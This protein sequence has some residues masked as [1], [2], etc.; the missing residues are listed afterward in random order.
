[1]IVPKCMWKECVHAVSNIWFQILPA[2]SNN[3]IIY[4][5]PTYR[6]LSRFFK[7]L[8]AQRYFCRSVTDGQCLMLDPDMNMSVFTDVSKVL[9]YMA[10]S[11]NAK[12]MRLDIV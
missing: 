7:I 8:P 6:V 1:M 12:N 9:H 10:L 5:Y 11:Y 2:K 4:I 3:L